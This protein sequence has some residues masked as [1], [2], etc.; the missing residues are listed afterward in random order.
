MDGAAAFL[1]CFSQAIKIVQLRL[2][3]YHYCLSSKLDQAFL[4][5]CQRM[6]GLCRLAEAWTIDRSLSCRQAYPCQEA[7][8]TVLISQ[9]STDGCRVAAAQMKV[10]QGI[11]ER[12][13]C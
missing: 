1:R 9:V 8:Q 3:Q 7:I 6:Q 13:A 11:R 5:R 12:P 4:Q 10:E 2:V